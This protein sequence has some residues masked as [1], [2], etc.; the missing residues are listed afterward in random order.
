MSHVPDRP[1]LTTRLV[2]LMAVGSGLSVASNYYVQ[3]LLPELGDAFDVSSSVVSLL[4]T[5][6][7]LG[8][9]AGLALV[10]PLGDLVE[11]RR[12]LTLV[13]AL[14]AGGLALIAAAPSLALLFPAVALVGIT[15]VAAQIFVPLSADLAE[16]D[17][18]GK[19]VGTVMAG[20]LVGIL[21][22]RTLAGLVAA[23]A[24]WRAVYVVAALAM[25]GLSAVSWRELPVVTPSASA[26][27]TYPSLLRSVVTLYREEPVLRRRGLYGALGFASFATLWTSLAFLLDDT[28][29]YGEATVGL[30]G[31]L[32]VAGAL[33]AQFAGRIADSGW[34]RVSTLGFF[35]TLAVS[36]AV[37]AAG[38][39]SLVALVLGIVLLDLAVQ[40]A[41]ISNQSEVYRLRPEARSRLTT[42]YMC[43]NFMGGVVGSASSAAVY[44]IGGWPL[45]CATGAGFSALALAVWATEARWPLRRMRH[46]PLTVAEPAIPG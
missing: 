11:R 35:V 4:V 1:R 3:P 46:P 26:S 43:V 10:V 6:S 17:Q 39:H 9:V 2:A 30:F 41:H 16:P 29:G 22:A 44:G 24:G 40:G 7:Q 25:L 37:L 13:T 32:G 38:S 42:A 28:Y 21:L 18:R 31:L 34:A 20:L 5:V 33:A 8:Y 15:S 14:T 36:W 23:L 19:A 27:T 45:V 12:L